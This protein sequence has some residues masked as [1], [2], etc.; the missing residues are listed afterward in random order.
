[1]PRGRSGTSPTPTPRPTGAA[2][3]ARRAPGRRSSAASCG[4]Y[5]VAQR[6]IEARQG[7][8]F[9]RDHRPGEQLRRHVPRRELPPVAVGPKIRVEAVVYLERM[10]GRGALGTAPTTRTVMNVSAAAAGNSDAGSRA[11]PSAL[12]RPGGRGRAS[13]PVRR[14]IEQIDRRPDP[15]RRPVSARATE[16]RGLACRMSELAATHPVTGGGEPARQSG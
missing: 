6:R 10:R 15:R 3:G 7:V 16:C 13:P 12:F 4:R 8:A 11:L 5:Q 1:M 14:E 9:R 2:P